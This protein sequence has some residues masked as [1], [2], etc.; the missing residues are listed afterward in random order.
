MPHLRTRS[1]SS[2]AV[3][4]TVSSKSSSNSTA[5]DYV[6][7]TIRCL[8]A[9]HIL[10]INVL[11]VQA[12]SNIVEWSNYVDM[13]AQFNLLGGVAHLIA[14]GLEWWILILM[15]VGIL[16]FCLRRDYTG[17]LIVHNA[18]LN[19]DMRFRGIFVGT[20]RAWYTN[21]DNLGLFLSQ[22]EDYFH[23]DNTN[24]GHCYS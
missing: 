2:T 4:Y 9:F 1:P 22:F 19:A 5:L 12:T 15:T 11:K 18:S 14:A 24:S 10:L 21:R 16:Y 17:I 13:I 7:H 8:T 6:K 20:S 23:S 3:L